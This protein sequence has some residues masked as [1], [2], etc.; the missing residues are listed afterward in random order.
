MAEQASITE[1]QDGS[2]QA[3]GQ[4]GSTG[5]SVSRAPGIYSSSKSR[6]VACVFLIVV[7]AVI[8]LIAVRMP[9]RSLFGFS[10][11]RLNQTW[12]AAQ[13]A[14]ETH[15][16]ETARSLLADCLEVSP[17]HAEGRF[18]MARAC[19]LTDDP[20]AWL[21]H[22]RMAQSLGWARHDIDLE[23]R[24]GEAQSKNIWIVEERLKQDVPEASPAEKTLIV[25][26]LING[27]LENDRPK[28][29]SWLALAWT[30]E[31]PEDWLGWLY[32]GRACQ[33]RHT[34]ANAIVNYEKVLDLK[35]DQPQARLW[36]ANTLASDTQFDRAVP[37]YQIYLQSHPG[38]ATALLGLAKCQYS[39]GHIEAARVAL[40]D[41]LHEHPNHAGGLLSRAQLEQAEAP[42]KALPWLRQAVAVAPNDTNILYNLALTLRAVHQDREAATYDQR[43]KERRVQAT[44]LAELETKLLSDANNVDLRYQLGRLNLELGKEDEAAHWF[45]TVL[46]IDPNHRPTLRALADYWQAHGDARRATFYAD[47]AEGKAQQF[48]IP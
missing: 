27:Y 9:W 44:R 8:G 12:D 42:E 43:L 30:L 22:L 17:Y 11:N 3:A 48:P 38:H 2:C 37:H 39:L 45:Q 15:E 1:K 10:D 5:A 18:L 19:R 28:D 16:Y 6:A 47:R 34:F 26:A 7:L 13:K 29:A 46:R 4:T 31:H 20:D 33:L 25:E 32:L 24:L 41:L 21:F 14:L 35:P 23:Y 36:L 40:D